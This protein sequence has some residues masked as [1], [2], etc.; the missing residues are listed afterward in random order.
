MTKSA[1]YLFC[2]TS[3]RS[4]HICVSLAASSNPRISLH[5]L[6]IIIEASNSIPTTRIAAFLFHQPSD[7]ARS[8]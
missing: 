3:G 4:F 1:W 5:R 6:M 7:K 8:A 2:A